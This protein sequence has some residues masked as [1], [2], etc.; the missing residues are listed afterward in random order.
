MNLQVEPVETIA[1][2]R[3]LG[4]E[5]QELFAAS[6]V[7]LPFFSYEWAECWWNHMR[8]ERRSVRDELHFRAIRT[9]T[10]QLVAI[11]PLVLTER[12]SIGPI[13]MR[14][15]Q[16]LGAD[17]NI[18]EMRGILAR[19]NFEREAYLALLQDLQE[20]SCDW[21]HWSGLC[22]DTEEAA[23]VRGRL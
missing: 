8:Q 19:P 11:A 14:Y 20:T 21:I 16:F 12:P 23:P 10:G 4:P 22:R 13:R 15:L 1:A 7:A 5:W 6:R 17:P 3:T 2:L 9:E 18:T